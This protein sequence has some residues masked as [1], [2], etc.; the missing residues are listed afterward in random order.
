MTNYDERCEKDWYKRVEEEFD[1]VYRLGV[2]K[3]GFSMRSAMMNVDSLLK[4]C[5]KQ[6]NKELRTRLAEQEAELK[7]WKDDQASCMNERCGDEVHCTCVPSLRREVKE[8]QNRLSTVE[9]ENSRLRSG[10]DDD[11]SQCAFFVQLQMDTE[12]IQSLE[13]KLS[14]LLK[15]S[16]GMEK[17]LEE[18]SKGLNLCPECHGSGNHLGVVGCDEHER[19]G[20]VSCFD[21]ACL[22]RRNAKKALADFRAVKELKK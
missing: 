16:E 20:L 19:Y 10:C 5:R 17:A 11:V 12:K 2:Y 4:S 9:A 21:D 22:A 18:V 15:A 8:L 7:E 6:E 14:T 3:K 1:I 13:Q